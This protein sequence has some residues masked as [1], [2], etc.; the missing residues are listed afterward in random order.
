MPTI[1][2]GD[3]P[4][5]IWPRADS[6]IVLS[7]ERAADVFKVFVEPGGAFSPGVGSFGVSVWIRL[8]PDHR[9]IAPELLPREAIRDRLLGGFL[10]IVR[11]RWR[12]G[13]LEL[14]LR[15]G[16]EPCPDRWH[17]LTTTWCRVVN[18]GRTAVAATLLLVVRS[19][20]AAGGAVRR[21]A[22]DSELRGFLMHDVARVV[23]QDVPLEFGCVS[24]AEDG[25]DIS[26]P[27][28]A[29]QRPERG[30]A[31]DADGYC[32]GYLG[33]PLVLEPGGD[34]ETGWD[35]PVLPRLTTLTEAVVGTVRQPARDRLETLADGWRERLTPV[36]IEAPDARFPE[37]FW[38]SLTHLVTAFAGDEPRIAPVCYPLFWTRDA[39]YII[40]ALDKGGLG[41]LARSGIQTML[42]RVWAG[43]FGP[44]ADTPGA[45]LW[46]LAE[47]FRLQ[48]DPERLRDCYPAIRERV[49]WLF[50]MRRATEPLRV[51]ACNVL[52]RTRLSPD[53]DL[54]C[55]PARDGLIQ[56]R[57]DWHQPLFW[58]NAFSL[59]GLRAAV[60]LAQLAGQPD[61]AQVWLAES[62]QLAAAL[63]EVG[64]NDND[65]SLACA[66]WPTGAR[67]PEDPVARQSY[68]RWWRTRRLD[69]RGHYHREPRWRYFELA[70][71]HNLLLLGHRDEVLTTIEQFL[72][73]QDAPGL[74]GWAE[75]D[76]NGDPSGDWRLIRGW[77]PDSK[78]MPHGWVAA[79]MAL[80]L[81][82]LFVLETPD[83]L[84]LGAG[85]PASWLEAPSGVGITDAP[86][87]HGKVSWRL[88]PY[89]P[90]RGYALTI[91]CDPEPPPGGYRLRLPLPP[92]A[93][94]EF[95]GAGIREDQ[96]DWRLPT[97]QV[98]TTVMIGLP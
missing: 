4:H 42:Q 19:F 78:I 66:I 79:E 12:A 73:T 91:R 35:C 65:R 56:G 37:A 2:R 40:N 3:H 61:D 36:K 22:Y 10:P 14:D 24:L 94:V 17:P 8:E 87:R 52:P 83:E 27:L 18:R 47:H 39:V 15:T 60:E 23:G 69:D 53:A 57:M 16:V 93:M 21:L 92:S 82:D 89:D 31:F 72:R 6:H 54:I 62:E 43:G 34:W 50:R 11:S 68:E 98:E 67:S 38:A 41:D 80:L 26:V 20:G 28:M 76:Q 25:C 84:I 55:E 48:P 51:D 86:T 71:A 49:E 90:A 58:V 74:Y 88:E 64:L 75:G 59:A 97:T 44:E 9:L 81:R 30:R 32:S 5:W 33:Y 13:A 7:A 46:C 45:A 63:A 29:G 70:Q 77:W 85:V 96:G 1:D 95:E